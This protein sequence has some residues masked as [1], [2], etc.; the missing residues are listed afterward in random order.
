MNKK[1]TYTFYV[2]KDKDGMRIDRFLTE[3][4]ENLSRS[5]LKYLI[6][7]G[8]VYLNQKKEF[9]PAAKVRGGSIC[10]VLLPE[11]KLA[12]P[13][14][15]YIPLDIMFED[16]YLIVIDKA[17]GLVVHPG[18]GNPDGT[19]V[20]ALL[21]HCK[22]SLS[23]IGG[24]S[25]PGIVHRLD[26]DTSGTMVV[27]KTDYTH[28]HLSSQFANHSIERI[29][30][31]IVWGVPK[32]KRGEI[33]TNI[34][35]SPLNRKKMKSVSRGGKI[36]QTQYR[37]KRIFGNIASSLECKLLTGRTH[38]IRVHMSEIGHAVIGDPVYG[39]R[40]GRKAYF[41]DPG[42]RIKVREFNRQALHASVLVFEHP[43]T[44]EKMKFVSKLSTDIGDLVRC[45]E[46][47]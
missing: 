39:S 26:K 30:N 18:A 21:A 5:R 3:S 10:D 2:P 8:Y 44:R 40:Q 42:I 4:S 24:V 14:S 15:Q 35:R 47:C 19:L 41:L 22:G 46:K 1:I 13:K 27:A 45:L 33:K 17:A 38:Q 36:A 29:Y 7:S 31:A 6:L 43:V 11:I 9:S 16:E 25:R 37:V 34:A 23:G 20:N 12:T 32:N 28:Q